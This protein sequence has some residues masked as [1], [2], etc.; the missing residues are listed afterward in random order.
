MTKLQY[1]L[2]LLWFFPKTL[3]IITQIVHKTITYKTMTQTQN[4]CVGIF[5][6]PRVSVYPTSQRNFTSNNISYNIV[7]QRMIYFKQYI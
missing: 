3:D 7:A 1:L 2:S 5:A 6:K 4:H